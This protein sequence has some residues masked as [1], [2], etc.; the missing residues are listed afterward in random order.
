MKTAKI[1]SALSLVLVFAASSLFAGRISDP[2]SPAKAKMVTYEVKVN[3]VPNFPGSN[4][5]YLVAITDETGRKV[6]PAQVFHSGVWSYT[7]KETGNFKGTRIAVL[8][9]Y[10]ATKTGWYAAPSVLKG[11]FYGDTS[12]RFELTP[13]YN[14]L[15][16]PAEKGN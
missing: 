2:G 14:E 1:I 11:F 6:V 10:P 12:Y 15:I 4:G 5:H 9:P 8:V 3:C 7:F 16:D 13:V